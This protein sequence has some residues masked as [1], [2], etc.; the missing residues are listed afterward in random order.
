[1]GNFG[2]V[3][4]STLHEGVKMGHFSYIGNTVIGAYKHW[5]GTITCNYDGEE[6]SN[7]DRRGCFHRLR[8]DA[9]GSTKTGRWRGPVQALL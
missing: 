3:K 5:A 4:D 2:E 8:H 9:C 6:A 1:M 7:G